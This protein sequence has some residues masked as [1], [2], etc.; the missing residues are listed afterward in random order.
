MQETKSFVV[1]LPPEGAPSIRRSLNALTNV[2][3]VKIELE[4]GDVIEFSSTSP[5]YALLKIAVLSPTAV[6]RERKNGM[7]KEVPDIFPELIEGIVTCSNKNCITA[8]PKEPTKPKFK[9][10]SIKPPKIQCFY[11]GRYIE[12]ASLISQLA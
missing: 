9:V 6:I 1:K 8:Q 3:S 12:Q 4:K 11:C 5:S 7:E 2:H 10:V